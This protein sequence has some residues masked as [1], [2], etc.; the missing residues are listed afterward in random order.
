[1]LLRTLGF[2]VLCSIFGFWS[3]EPS[4][5]T[6]RNATILLYV[7]RTVHAPGK[8]FC[9]PSHQRPPSTESKKAGS[10]SL[11]IKFNDKIVCR[12]SRIHWHI[13][14]PINI[15]TTYHHV[16][17]R[18]PSRPSMR[19]K[20]SNRLRRSPPAHTSCWIRPNRQGGLDRHRCLEQE[21][22]LR[23]GLYNQ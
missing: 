11:K 15:T 3:L 1:M 10:S 8:I 4:A 12:L 9:T 20:P 23:N 7:L 21:L 13:I 6:L 19:H 14:I 2:C 5:A 17:H 16:L 22:L 18:L